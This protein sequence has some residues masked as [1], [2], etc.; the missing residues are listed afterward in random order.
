MILSDRLRA[1]ARS[2]V[3]APFTVLDDKGRALIGVPRGDE[4]RAG[5]SRA[6]AVRQR[7]SARERCQT[8][9]EDEDVREVL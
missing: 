5:P 9:A 2:S 3:T 1:A 8:A 4:P 6:A 7:R